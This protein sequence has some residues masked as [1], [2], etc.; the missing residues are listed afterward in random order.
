MLYG[1]FCF[2]KDNK[3]PQILNNHNQENEKNRTKQAVLRDST[4]KIPQKFS[5]ECA[6]NKETLTD[7]QK[8]FTSD[9]ERLFFI[10]RANTLLRRMLIHKFL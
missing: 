4:K 8:P 7:K 1:G 6:K 3:Y 2:S 9:C 5:E 10:T